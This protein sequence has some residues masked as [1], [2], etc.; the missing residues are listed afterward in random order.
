[1]DVE[2]KFSKGKIILRAKDETYLSAKSILADKERTDEQRYNM[3]AGDNKVHERKLLSSLGL[4]LSELKSSFDKISISDTMTD[5]R[6]SFV[7]TMVLSDRFKLERSADLQRMAEEYLYRRIVA[8]WWQT[9]YPELAESYLSNVS[10]SLDGIKRLLSLSNPYEGMY[11]PRFKCSCSCGYRTVLLY[12]EELL[13]EIHMEM[14]KLSRSTVND[15]GVADLNLQTDEL[16]D[17]SL[18]TRYINRHIGR[19]CSRI[20]AYLYELSNDYDDD[21]MERTPV[22]KF[23]LMMPVGWDDRMFEQLAEEIHSYVVNASITEWLKSYFPDMASVF[24][25]QADSAWD[26]VKHIVS[27][28]KGGVRKPIQPF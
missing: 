23:K 10:V 9:N 21:Q 26:N 22:Y 8:D 13:N 1:M 6:D 12:K 18:M 14:L 7:V 20:N 15:K 4:A 2:L 19:I 27:V 24:G 17:E 28:R 11:L 25:S 3:Q 5:R 16:Y